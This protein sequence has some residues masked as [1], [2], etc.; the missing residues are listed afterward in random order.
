[1]SDS[2]INKKACRDLALRW[3]RDNR[4]GWMPERVSDKHFLDELNT[5]VRMM[6][7]QAVRSHR[8]VGKTIKDF[9]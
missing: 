3:G 9:L 4:K 7:I 2:Y 1:M 5:K 6:I 8:S